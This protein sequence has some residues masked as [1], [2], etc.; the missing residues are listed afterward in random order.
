MHLV[1][2]TLGGNEPSSCHI[3]LQPLPGIHFISFTI[4]NVRNPMQAMSHWMLGESEIKYLLTR[5][6]ICRFLFLS[7]LNHDWNL[8]ECIQLGARCDPATASHQH[9]RVAPNPHFEIC[10]C[11][12]QWSQVGRNESD[13]CWRSDGNWVASSQQ[14]A[15]PHPGLMMGPTVIISY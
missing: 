11:G 9:S 5:L 10:Q 1:N 8:Y 3:F 13:F 4:L 2:I 6:I 15:S 7:F 12:V 14:P